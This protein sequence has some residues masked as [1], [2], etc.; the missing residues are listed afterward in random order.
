MSGKIDTRAS[1]VEVMGRV[2]EDLSPIQLLVS[3]L[4][5]TSN[6]TLEAW[7]EDLNA[8]D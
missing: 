8:F 5:T 3:G 4:D 2:I 7:V 1:S 6:A